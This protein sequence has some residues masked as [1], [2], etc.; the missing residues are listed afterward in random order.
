LKHLGIVTAL[1]PEAKFFTS[2]PVTET[3]VRIS[4]KV[5]LIVSGMGQDRAAKATRRLIDGG[6]DGL[7][8]TGTAGALSTD[9]QPGD[10][11]MPETIFSVHDR[12]F[13][14]TRNW[15]R[16]ALDCFAGSAVPIHTRDLFSGDTIVN[17][18]DGKKRLADSTGA[19]A[20]DTESAAMMELAASRQL[21]CLV[22]RSII[23]PGSFSIPGTIIEHTGPYGEPAGISM[24]RSAF[25]EPKLIL[26]FIQL[27]WFFRKAGKSLEDV[28]RQTARLAEYE[29]ER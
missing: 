25:F 18:A 4:D 20:V 28:G 9:L 23:D 15:H 16:Y 26:T 19:I 10:L 12:K 17:R 21:P 7:L 29:S 2:H 24:L 27:A 22:I 5:S 11:I 14:V 1:L 3:P 8:C 6:V 13:A